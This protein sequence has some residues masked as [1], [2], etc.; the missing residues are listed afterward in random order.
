MGKTY[1]NQCGLSTEDKFEFFENPDNGLY[2]C[3]SCFLK[4]EITTQFEDEVHNKC[5][6]IDPENN[7]DWRSI[8]IGFALGKGK[9]PEFAVDFATFIRYHTTLG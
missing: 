5:D 9:S 2:L 6:K 3:T 1:C 8:T 7:E 4:E